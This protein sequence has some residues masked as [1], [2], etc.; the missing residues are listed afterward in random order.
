M[1]RNSQMKIIYGETLDR[2]H[3]ILQLVGRSRHKAEVALTRTLIEIL[4]N[5]GV[6]CAFFERISRQNL[7]STYN[8]MTNWSCS[9]GESEADLGQRLYDVYREFTNQYTDQQSPEKNSLV[10]PNLFLG[11]KSRIHQPACS[12]IESQ[13]QLSHNQFRSPES[14]FQR[15]SPPES[16]LQIVLDCL[17]AGFLPATS[18]YLARKM[19][20]EI[21]R[22]L[23]YKLKRMQLHCPSG[24][25]LMMVPDCEGVLEDHQISLSFSVPVVTENGEEMDSVKGQVLLVS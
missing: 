12:R 9:E 13:Y 25:K 17:N 22:R 10:S 19:I 3:C 4:D 23:T 6:N 18:P 21:H 7:Q 14:K 1:L 16:N 15:S 8:A 2:S 20:G 11:S 5:Q 24:I